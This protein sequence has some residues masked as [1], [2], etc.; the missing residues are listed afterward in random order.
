MGYWNL[1]A[2]PS[3]STTGSF[4]RS[5]TDVGRVRCSQKVLDRFCSSSPTADRGQHF[6][7]EPKQESHKHRV[8]PNGWKTT[9]V[10]TFI[11]RRSN[12]ISITVFLNR[13][14]ANTGPQTVET[15]S[16]CLSTDHRGAEEAVGARHPPIKENK[17]ACSPE[18]VVQDSAHLHAK[19]LEYVNSCFVLNWCSLC[20]CVK[21]K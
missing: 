3:H 4:V 19:R 8:L 12:T 10:W 9:V 15:T 1:P 2:G 14:H 7:M 18:R 21:P 17:Q 11:V 16:S 20:L 5:N 6:F 13:L